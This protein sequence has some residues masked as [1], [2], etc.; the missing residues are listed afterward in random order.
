[1]TEIAPQALAPLTAQQQRDLIR[2]FE[3]NMMLKNYPG[4]QFALDLVEA[5]E[6]VRDIISAALNT[7]AWQVAGGN[8]FKT[9]TG[10]RVHADTGRSGPDCVWQ[11]FVF[12]LALEFKQNTTVNALGNRLLILNQKWKGDAA[13]FLHGEDVEPNE[14]NIVVRDYYSEG[15]E[16]LESPDY[17]DP[18]LLKY[19]PHLNSK[20]FFGLSVDKD[21]VWQPGVPITFPRNRLHV[22]SAFPRCGIKSKLG[23]SIFTS[24][25]G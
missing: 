9:E 16:D 4:R 11:T 7:D 10:Y 20:N 5:T 8:F 23:L 13:F 18:L 3:T 1:M 15:V 14:Y 21:F 24:R 2:C 17:V 22:S 19:C 25:N 6:I 12:P